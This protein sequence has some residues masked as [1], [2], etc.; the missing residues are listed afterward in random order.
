VVAFH[1][2]S[3]PME[4]EGR[5]DLLFTPQRVYFRGNRTVRLLL[6][7]ARAHVL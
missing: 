6:R 2:S 1:R 4:T 3:L 5:L 7:D